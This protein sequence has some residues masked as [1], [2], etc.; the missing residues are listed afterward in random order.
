MIRVNA[1][2]GSKDKKKNPAHPNE[3][4]ITTFSCVV[5]F[6][7]GLERLLY[8]IKKKVKICSRR[9]ALV[10]RRLQYQCTRLSSC[11][12]CSLFFFCLLFRRAKYFLR[13]LQKRRKRY[14][15]QHLFI[16]LWLITGDFGFLQNTFCFY[17]CVPISVH[18]DGSV[19]E[20]LWTNIKL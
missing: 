8:C 16:R 1:C 10:I 6:G 11:V 14:S 19:C 20:T 17:L 7:I 12:V 3:L 13:T 9:S 2:K 15:V 18:I 5:V 4:S